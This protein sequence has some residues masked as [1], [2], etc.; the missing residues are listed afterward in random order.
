VSPPPLEHAKLQVLNGTGAGQELPRT[1]PSVTLGK[2]SSKVVQLNQQPG[3]HFIAC[4]DQLKDSAPPRVSGKDIDARSLKVGNHDIIE[5]NRL[6]ISYFR[7]SSICL[8]LVN[9][10]AQINHKVTYHKGGSI[11]AFMVFQGLI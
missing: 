3:G 4:L 7:A 9:L 5:I 6:N 11:A 8:A 2:A 10:T 1:K